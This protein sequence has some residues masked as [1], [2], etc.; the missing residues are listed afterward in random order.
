MCIIL[1]DV[2][3]VAQTNLF[4]LAN[5]DKT[6]QLTLYSNAVET[7]HENLMVLPVPANDGPIELHTLHYK[8]LFQDLRNSVSKIQPRTVR[9]NTRSLVV[10]ASCVPEERLEVILHG[11]YAVSIAPKLED[12]RRLDSRYFTATEDLIQFFAKHYSREFRYICCVL[13][14]GEQ[15]YE[16][17]CYSHPLHSSGKL[18]VPTLHY[19]KHN[20][21][22]ETST[23]D[24]DHRIFSVGTEE[25]ANLGYVSRYEN[26]VVWSLFPPDYQ[27]LKVSSVRCAEIHGYKHNTD[28]SFA[29]Y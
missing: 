4:V 6:R 21:K 20:G 13:R 7:P 29:L 15:A 9:A 25:K 19:H 10:S 27:K 23:A 3:R 18:F 14:Q 11:S 17:L 24:W 12:L 16:P 8:N 1:G 5:K 2:Y 22:V 26:S 28:I